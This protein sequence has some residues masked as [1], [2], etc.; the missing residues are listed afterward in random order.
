MYGQMKYVQLTK[1]WKA[2]L[3]RDRDTFKKQMIFKCE[4]RHWTK[5]SRRNIMNDKT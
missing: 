2:T 1:K 5:I 4:D 3:P